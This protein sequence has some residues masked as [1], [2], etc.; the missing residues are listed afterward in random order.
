MSSL[1]W[2][3]SI[4]PGPFCKALD[5]I[6]EKMVARECLSFLFGGGGREV[7]KE[8]WALEVL[9]HDVGPKSERKKLEATTKSQETTNKTKKICILVFKTIIANWQQLF[10]FLF[11]SRFVPLLTT[12]VTAH[13]EKKRRHLTFVTAKEKCLGCWCLKKGSFRSRSHFNVT[14][15]YLLANIFRRNLFSHLA[16]ASSRY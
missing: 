15:C 6:Q 5:R 9:D 16:T 2:R 4:S 7:R 14:T 1:V 8:V 11:K 13:K 3:D 10:S 12:K